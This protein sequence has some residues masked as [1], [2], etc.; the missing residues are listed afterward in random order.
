[1]KK[2]IEDKK[3]INRSAESM[4]DRYRKYLKFLNDEN[5]ETILNYINEKSKLYY[6]RPKRFFR[7]QK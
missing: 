2:D 1:M 4:R 6:I 5:L 3:F 7:I